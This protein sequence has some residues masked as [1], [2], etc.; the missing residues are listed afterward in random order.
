MQQV[1]PTGYGE[2]VKRLIWVSF[3]LNTG[4]LNLPTSRAANAVSGS[5][6]K[7]CQQLSRVYIELPAI[8][9]GDAAKPLSR[10]FFNVSAAL[11]LLQ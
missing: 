7:I 5:C 9:G 10:L 8:K 4:R 1:Q 11:E 3:D 2:L 6:S